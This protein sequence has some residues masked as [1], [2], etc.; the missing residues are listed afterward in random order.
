MSFLQ[1]RMKAFGTANVSSILNPIDLFN[2]KLVQQK[3]HDYLRENQTEFL[4]KWETQRATR[5]VVGIME[6]GSGK[7]LVGLLMLYS[8]AQELKEPVVYLCPDKQLVD[9][10][11]KQASLYGIPVCQIYSDE[12]GKQM[13]PIEFSNS[14]AVLV[15]TFEKLF[16]GKSIFGVVG[17]NGREIQNI[18]ALLIDDAHECIKKA[19]NKASIIIK[20]NGQ[21]QLFKQFLSIF[22]DDLENQSVGALKSI[23][24]G[25]V[26]V[27]KQIPYWAWNNKLSAVIDLLDQ[28]N[29]KEHSNIYF[30]FDLVS[31]SLENCECYISGNQIEITPLLIPTNKIPSYEKAKHRYILSATLGNN[32]DLLKELGVSKEAI[33]NPITVDNVNMGER[34]I[35]SPKRINRDITDSEIR[36]LCKQYSKETNVAVIVPDE[37]K[38]RLWVEK[39][40]KLIGNENI[41]N[42]LE[43]IK[44]TEKGNFVVFLNRY[45]GIDLI[46]AA[47]RILVIDGMPTR[48]SLKEK[49]EARY[50]N[51]SI[52]TNL[53]KAQTI[54]QGLGRGVRSGT[55]HC[56][57][58]LMG[59]SLINFVSLNSNKKLF[60]SV[61]QAQLEFGLE[62]TGG[63]EVPKDE[64]FGIIN[65]AIQTCLDAEDEWRHFHKNLVNAAK[66]NYSKIDLER[67]LTIAENERNSINAAVGKDID[68]VSNNFGKLLALVT[69]TSD[70]AYMKQLYAHLLNDLDRTRSQDLQL[71]AYEINNALI[72]PLTFTKSRKVK[73]CS[74]Q[75]ARFKQ[76]IS[77]YAKGTDIA[78]KIESILSKMIYNQNM[79]HKDFENAIK[80]LGDFLGF[81]STQPDMGTNDGPDN[82]WVLEN[83]DFVIECKNQSL[84]NISRDEAS[85]MSSSIRWYKERFAENQRLVPIML[86][87]SSQLESNAYANEEFVVIDSSHLDLLKKNLKEL[88]DKLSLKSPNTWMD[89]ELKGF[90]STCKL[91][92]SDFLR[93][94][95]TS[96]KRK[97]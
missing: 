95:T 7:T 13:F 81:K 89:N 66:G 87:R 59:S 97:R 71:Q 21:E 77:N 50:R 31:D 25:E 68:A 49:I 83:N 69:D 62:L 1:N 63:K 64:A 65:E 17:N 11:Y 29:I 52:F 38:S 46:D 44:G 6:T 45:D 61:V 75:L 67:M 24:R 39:G 78:I 28:Y 54:E 27:I 20:K 84:N 18:G 12:Y 96:V 9:Q 85:Q 94:Y 32:Y 53:K 58:I 34:L 8:K 22:K 92:E 36:D 33:E 60:N 82:F 88:G 76:L 56:V 5:D 30:N 93:T 80:E 19:R 35:I 41:I 43:A 70:E 10:V 91:Q 55:D 2:K 79:S 42:D 15:T 3:S 86:H 47:C 16:N 57:A 4:K 72:K 37:K 40:A 73:R 48:E 74:N 51:E 26:S 14:E 90:L 23:V